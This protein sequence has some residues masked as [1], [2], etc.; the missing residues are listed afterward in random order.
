[1]LHMQGKGNVEDPE[2]VETTVT[3]AA[4]PMGN[5]RS[6]RRDEEKKTLDNIVVALKRT[7]NPVP[8]N[9][10]TNVLAAALDQFSNVISTSF[11]LWQDCQT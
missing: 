8:N 6:K 5:E 1:M 4:H 2:L 7:I 11:Q 10:A 9:S 3:H